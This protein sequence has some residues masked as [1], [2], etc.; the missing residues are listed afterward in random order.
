MPPSVIMHHLNLLKCNDAPSSLQAALTRQTLL[1]EEKKVAQLDEQILGLQLKLERMT[2][3]RDKSERAAQDCRFILSPIRKLP[4]EILAEIF[5]HCED[6]E[7]LYPPIHVL[8]VDPDPLPLAWVCRSW[9]NVVLSTPQL[10]RALKIDLTKDRERYLRFP[11]ERIQWYLS[12]SRAIPLRL[13]VTWLDTTW[14]EA[15]AMKYLRLFMPHFDRWESINVEG[16][17]PLA[18]PLPAVYT[19]ETT[20]LRDASF[21]FHSWGVNEHSWTESI[22][23]LADRSLHRLHWTGPVDIFVKLP[24][25]NLRSLKLLQWDDKVTSGTATGTFLFIVRALPLLEEFEGVFMLGSPAGLGSPEDLQMTVH[26][27]LRI[28][29]LR[30]FDSFSFSSLF[31]FC[32]LPALTHVV[33]IAPNRHETWPQES[34]TSFLTRSSA[35]ILSLKIYSSGITEQDMLGLLQHPSIT[36]TLQALNFNIDTRYKGPVSHITPTAVLEFLTPHP[37]AEPTLPKLE[38]IS[39]GLDLETQSRIFEDLLNSRWVAPHKNADLKQVTTWMFHAR[40]GPPKGVADAISVLQGR[41]VR[42]L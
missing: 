26:P 35:S 13:D 21:S 22:L 39:L 37:P 27:N 25:S 2:M 19:G 41:G 17:S 40:N 30:H 3:L 14:Q 10:W 42:F 11:D 31:D 38:T 33:I 24:F 28:L 29:K 12:L 9:R 1:D 4:H 16:W 36:N 34:F 5:S 32:I 23:R 6:D 15:T 20:A 7:F 8:A 18:L